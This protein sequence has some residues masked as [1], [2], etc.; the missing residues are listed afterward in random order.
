MRTPQNGQTRSNH[1]SGKRINKSSA[2]EYISDTLKPLLKHISIVLSRMK[3]PVILIG[4]MV[5]SIKSKKATGLMAD[6]AILVRGKNYYSI[7][8]TAV[9]YFCTM[10]RKGSSFLMTLENSRNKKSI[11]RSPT[12]GFVEAIVDKDISSENRKMQAHS[13]TL[14]MTQPRNANETSDALHWSKEHKNAP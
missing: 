3:L 14:K 5:T 7:C 12:D 9:L 4:N 13:M 6:L 2:K 8:I 1:S 10:K 11:L